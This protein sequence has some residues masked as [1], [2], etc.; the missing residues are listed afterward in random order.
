MEAKLRP[1]PAV[2]AASRE[3]LEKSLRPKDF[4]RRGG[5][6]HRVCECAFW[7]VALV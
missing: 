2:S 6:A 1:A 5:H 7:L 4:G 3:L